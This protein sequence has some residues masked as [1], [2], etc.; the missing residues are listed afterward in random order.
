M[1]IGH[2]FVAPGRLGRLPALIAAARESVVLVYGVTA[3]LLI[4]AGIEAFWS[5]ASWIPP[6]VKYSV[7]A[8]CWTTVL[9]YFIFQG[10]RVR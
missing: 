5:S 3:M 2:S 7:A 8:V 1:R 9:C 6:P 10:R 4:A